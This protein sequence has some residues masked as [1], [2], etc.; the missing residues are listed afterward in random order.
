M[1]VFLS[2]QLFF[3]WLQKV[4]CWYQTATV[5]SAVMPPAT[6]PPVLASWSVTPSPNTGSVSR[7]RTDRFE[8]LS[9]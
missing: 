7:E 3:V 4:T 5:S 9:L 8:A 6:L 1:R 2:S